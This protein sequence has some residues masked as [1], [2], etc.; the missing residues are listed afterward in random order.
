MATAILSFSPTSA[1][2]KVKLAPTNVKALRLYRPLG[3]RR[4]TL[5]QVKPFVFSKVIHLEQLNLPGSGETAIESWRTQLDVVR[6]RTCWPPRTPRPG[7]GANCAPKAPLRPSG[8]SHPASG[9]ALFQAWT[10]TGARKTPLKRSPGCRMGANLI[11]DLIKDR[12]ARRAVCDIK[13]AYSGMAVAGG[14]L[15]TR[16]Y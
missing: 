10:W 3:V 1:R 11:D 5:F 2:E 7:W 16:L 8:Q 13:F 14:K 4:T 6:V 15:L 9:S 12:N